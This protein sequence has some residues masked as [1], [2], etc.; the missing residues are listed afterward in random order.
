[1]NQY[2]TVNLE[3]IINSK[4]EEN[5]QSQIRQKAMLEKKILRIRTISVKVMDI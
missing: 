5:I 4:S 1:M 2:F 3:K